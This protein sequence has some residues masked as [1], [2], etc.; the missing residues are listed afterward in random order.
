MPLEHPL[1]ARGLIERLRRMLGTW[2]GLP[3]PVPG[4]AE[5]A[6]AAG[7]AIWATGHRVGVAK[8]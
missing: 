7:V 5:D 6:V 4:A 1:H 2:T 8:A 3:D